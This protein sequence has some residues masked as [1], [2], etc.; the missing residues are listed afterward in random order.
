MT[1][2]FVGALF[3]WYPIGFLLLFFRLLGVYSNWDRDHSMTIGLL[4]TANL[5]LAVAVGTNFGLFLS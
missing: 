4:G 3:F 2:G 1:I 5:D